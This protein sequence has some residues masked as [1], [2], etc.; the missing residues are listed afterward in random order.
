[1]DKELTIPTVGPARL[2]FDPERREVT[3]TFQVPLD[4]LS[5]FGDGL[6]RLQSMEPRVVI[7]ITGREA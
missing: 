5:T 3:I 2:H 7:S 4:D 6:V 1:M